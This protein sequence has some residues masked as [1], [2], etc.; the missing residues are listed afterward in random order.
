M[1]KLRIVAYAHKLELYVAFAAF[2]PPTAMTLKK[3]ETFFPRSIYITNAY[4]VTT[5][6]T[7]YIGNFHPFHRRCRWMSCAARTRKIEPQL[8]V[9]RQLCHSVRLNEF[10]VWEKNGSADG[11]H[12][13]HKGTCCQQTRYSDCVRIN[14]DL[15]KTSKQ[16]KQRTRTRKTKIECFYRLPASAFVQWI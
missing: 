1:N 3:G 16:L 5:S 7:H 11:L 4:V 13:L 15:R 12:G 14:V 6:S 2:T 10:N 9:L 8:K